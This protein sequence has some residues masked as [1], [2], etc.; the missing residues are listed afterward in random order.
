VGHGLG[1]GASVVRAIDAPWAY[2]LVYAALLFQAGLVGMVLYG[3]G[4]LWIFVAGIGVVRQIPQSASIMLPLLAGLAG[5]L[6]ANATNPYLLK[7]DYLWALFLPIAAINVYIR[8]RSGP[9]GVPAAVA[10]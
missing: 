7:F 5:F 8:R 9:D 6:I 4:V 2:E 1:A 3:V 10:V